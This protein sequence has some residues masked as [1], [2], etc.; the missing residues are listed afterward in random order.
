MQS[1]D[2]VSS[3]MSVDKLLLKSSVHMHVPYLGLSLS[4]LDAV[5]IVGGACRIPMIKDLVAET[6][7]RETSTTLNLDEAVARGCA[8]QCAI[9]SPAFKVRDFSISDIQPFPI[10]LKWQAAMEGEEG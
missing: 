8:L 10:K 9:L 1:L 6:F 4:E 2:L 5:E 3:T 7:K